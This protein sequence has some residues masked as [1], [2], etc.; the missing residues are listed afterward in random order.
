MKFL[1]T[2]GLGFIGTNLIKFLIEHYDHEILNLD[3]VTYASNFFNNKKFSNYKFY[4]FVKGDISDKNLVKKLLEDFKPDFIM[5][6]AAESHVD[7]SISCPD[8]FVNTNI[9]GTYN[10]LINARDYWV[11]LSGEKKRNFRFHH[12]STDEVYGSIH[13]G[14]LFNESSPYRPNSPYAA[15]KASSDHLVRAWNKT[16][17]LPTLISNCSNN[18]GP[19]QCPEKLIPLIILNALKNKKLPIYGNGLQIRDWLHVNDHVKALY[20]IVTKGEIGETY[21]VGANNQI[22]NINLVK[23]ICNFLDSEISKK[24]KNLNSFNELIS[25][26]SDRPGHDICYGI[27]PEKLFNQLGWKPETDFKLGI[28]ATIKWYLDNCFLYD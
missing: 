23:M 18:Y 7:R 6:L 3:K 5:N 9:L 13:Q 11:N 21:N 19:Y 12:I 28:E 17:N 1:I 2:G 26:V 8:A 10:L 22:S 25:Y 14:D 27:N 20:I 4:N 16:Y 15:S 24:P